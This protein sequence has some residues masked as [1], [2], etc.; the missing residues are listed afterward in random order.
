MI[1]M[2]HE[3]LQDI[4]KINQIPGLRHVEIPENDGEEYWATLASLKATL[5][6]AC[7]QIS[8]MVAKGMFFDEVRLTPLLHFILSNLSYIR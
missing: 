2:Y 4:E 7:F 8:V 3:I 6:Y 5:K 1:T